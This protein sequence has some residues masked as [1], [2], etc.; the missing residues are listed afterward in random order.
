MTQKYV[1][2]AFVEKLRVVD[3]SITGVARLLFS[4]AKFEDSLF[5]EG[6]KI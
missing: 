5:G 3:W 4:R 1:C 6:L 2:I